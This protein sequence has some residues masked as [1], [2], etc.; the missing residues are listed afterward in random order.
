MRSDF[1]AVL[2]KFTFNKQ[3]LGLYRNSTDTILLDYI[4]LVS[5]N[6]SLDKSFKLF[7]EAKSVYGEVIWGITQKTSSS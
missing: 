5:T 6:E 4:T 3:K 2:W 1:H 7:S